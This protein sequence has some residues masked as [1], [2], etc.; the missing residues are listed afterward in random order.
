MKQYPSKF[1]EHPLKF[2]RNEAAGLPRTAGLEATC[3]KVRS[4]GAGTARAVLSKTAR[5]KIA[6]RWKEVVTAETGYETYEAFREGVN[7]E[8]GRS[9]G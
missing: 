2:A 3:G 5:D 6:Q 4:G 7:K 1:D 9:F 8:L